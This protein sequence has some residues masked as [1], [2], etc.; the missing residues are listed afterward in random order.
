MNSNETL[1]ER[2]TLFWA[3]HFVCRGQNILHIEKYNNILRKN[4]LGN[5]RVFVKEV[6]HSASMLKYLN[7]KQ[8]KKQ[9]PNENFTRELMELFTLGIGNYSENDI[10]EAAKAFT[11]GTI[12][13]MV[14]IFYA[15]IN[16][17]IVKKLSLASQVILMVMKL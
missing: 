5:F 16:M 14:I 13:P 4:A 1:R 15:K 17:I 9:S 12:N 7:A 3:N 2:M 8:N 6:A 11:G 10:K